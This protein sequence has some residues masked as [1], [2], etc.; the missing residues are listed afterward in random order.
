MQ[1]VTESVFAALRRVERFLLG[2][3]KDPLERGIFHRISLIAFFAWV[4]LGSD[5]LTSSCYGP[6]EA[7]LALG[8]HVH[9]APFLALAT[10]LTVAIIA[11]SYTQIIE[12]FPSGGGGYIVASRLLSPTVG[13]ISGCALVVDYILTIA[14]S[15]ASGVDALLSL[16]SH[17]DSPLKPVLCLLVILLLVMLNLRGVK[18]SVQALL[19]IFLLFVITHTILILGT[20]LVHL[21]HLPVMVHSSVSETRDSM[22]AIGIFATMFI[23]LRAFSMGAGTYTGIEAVSNGLPVLREPRVRTGKRTMLYMAISLALTAGGILIGY[24]LFDIHQQTG[25]TLNA[26]LL[27]ALADGWNA[28]ATI[29]WGSVF[30]G[31]TLLAEG[32]LLFV[33]AQTGFVDGPRVLSSMAIDRWVPNRFANISSR[34]VTSNGV[35]LMAAAASILLIYTKAG[36]KHLVVMYSINVFITFSLSQL[37][38]VRHWWQVRKDQS[39]WRHRLFLNGLGLAISA[40]ILLITV[41]LKFLQGGWLTV[42]ITGSFVGLAFLV[43]RHY[44][45]VGFAL[46]MLN[47]LA[48]NPLPPRPAAAAARKGRTVAI[49]VNRYDGLGLHTLGRV[50]SLIGEDLSRLIFLSVAQVDSDQFRSEEQIQ[51]LRRN[52]DADLGR[53]RALAERA[54]LEAEVHYEVGTDVVETLERLAVSVAE[55]EPGILFVA[56]QIVFERETVVTRLLHN[57]VAFALQRRLIF[58]GLDVLVLPVTM[59]QE[60]LDLEEGEAL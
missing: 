33:A 9:L 1:S 40:T 6:E 45:R 20:A 28:R 60:A 59:P 54:G 10:A 12:L 43:R 49:F 32:A 2:R 7:Y 24:R 22:G 31:L 48:V 14:V 11:A 23:F 42:V 3:E 25:R 38:M 16:F 37:G 51:E 8:S 47:V 21:D 18:E 29:P 4:G 58:R 19:P 35:L 5:G 44:R 15:I 46:T 26:S 55:R 30:I 52:R 57:E 41:S 34:L 13:V 50:R 17:A 27:H 56:G 36:V 53:Y 39:G